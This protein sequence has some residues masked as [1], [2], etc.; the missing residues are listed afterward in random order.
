MN[1]DQAGTR[2]QLPDPPHALDEQSARD[3]E[4][5]QHTRILVNQLENLLARQ[6]D[7]AIGDGFELFQALVRL[8]LAAVAFAQERQRHKRQ[9]Q[10]A[11][12]LGRARDDRADAAAR[13]AAQAGDDQNRIRT[14]ASRLE[15]GKLFLGDGLA[16]FGVA[17]GAEAAQQLGLEMD[18]RRR[19]H[20]RQGRPVS[21]DGQKA[22]AGKFPAV[23][24]VEQAHAGI[25]DADDFDRARPVGFRW[26]G[27]RF[28]VGVH[29]DS[30][31]VFG[32]G[33]GRSACAPAA[34]SS[35][36]CAS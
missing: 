27:R 28:L 23:Q 34:I 7:D 26:R 6:R 10:R 20:R 31:N 21:V 33:K 14:L 18:F 25:A 4:R 24:R 19:R 5:V 2:E 11:R 8:L 35:P 13:A 36:A 15:R 12:F 32:G 17:T 16:A 3:A 1:L 9:H 29:G 22:R 30:I